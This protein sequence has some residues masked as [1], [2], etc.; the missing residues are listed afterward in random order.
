EELISEEAA[1]LLPARVPPAAEDRR[2]A[3]PDRFAHVEDR[4]SFLAEEPLVRVG[5]EDVDRDARH[6]ERQGAQALD[7]VE[8]E[9]GASFAAEAADFLERKDEAVV[10]RHPGDGDDLRV[11]IDS[12]RDVV[13]GDAAGPRRNGAVLD[14]E[15]LEEFPGQR[16]GRKLYVVSDDV[17]PRL[18]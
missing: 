9:E 5:G 16:V 7:S 4:A 17:V 10:K 3:V 14:T 11:R 18:P 1:G 8:D 15:V 13:E 12:C 2:H 6:V